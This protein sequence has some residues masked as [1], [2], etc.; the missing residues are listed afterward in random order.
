MLLTPLAGAADVTMFSNGAAEVSVEVRDSPEYTNTDD[1]TVTLPS[2]DTVTSASMSISTGM[3]KHQTYSTINGDTAQY[4]WDPSF[5]NQQTE[6]STLTDFTYQE[7]TIKLVSGGFSTDF[8]RDNAGFQD[9]TTG[10]SPVSYTHL[11]L[12]TSDLV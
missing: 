5:N 2:G 10:L 4:V 12:P 8:E 7:D 3:A 6:F 11:T 9:I 1:G